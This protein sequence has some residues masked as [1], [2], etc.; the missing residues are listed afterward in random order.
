MKARD[1][2]L[3]AIDVEAFLLA[4]DEETARRLALTLMEELGLPGADVVFL[5]WRGTGA[6]VRIRSYAHRPGDDYAWLGGGE[7]G[8]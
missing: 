3:D 5:E 7:R 2:V 1:R 8:G 4:E 6:R